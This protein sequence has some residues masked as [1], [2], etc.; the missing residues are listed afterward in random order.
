MK[1]RAVTIITKMEL[2]GA[3]EVALF[4]VRNLS[5]DRYDV[6][7]ISGEGGGLAAEAKSILGAK[8]I[9]VP[10]MVRE[11][12]PVKDLRALARLYSIIRRLVRENPA[13]VLVHTHS[14]KAGILGRLAAYLAGA[15]VVVHSVHGFGFN[16]HQ[17]PLKRNAYILIERLVAGVTDFFVADA[18]DN[19]KKGMRAGIFGEGRA[20]VIRSGIDTAYY[21]TPP[22]DA[23]GLK[24]GLGLPDGAPVALMVACLK[25]QKAPLD[26]VRVA[27]RVLESVPEA[28]FVHVGDGELRTEV[29]AEV[30]RLGISGNFHM[31]GW[32]RDIRELIHISDVM[33]LT[34]LWEGLPKVLLEAMAAGKPIVATTV[35]GT[36]EAVVDGRDGFLA[37]PHDIARMSEKAALLLSDGPLA[38]RMGEAGREMVSEFEEKGMLREIEALYDNLLKEAA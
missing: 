35:D 23:A 21:S 26:Y 16:D 28:H 11:I 1:V 19:I 17:G 8:F 20:K 32:R 12:S 30:A 25:P 3:Q 24:R 33:V 13:G 36:P 10:E 15:R 27:A 7:L 34:S 6:T 37:E 5:R 38:R 4:T 29:E 18:Y 14:S 9:E 22:D 31:L 2:G